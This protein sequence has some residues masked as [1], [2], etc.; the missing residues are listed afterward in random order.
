MKKTYIS[1]AVLVVAMNL[2]QQLC[3]ISGGGTVSV[4]D[5][6]EDAVE[7]SQSL[8]RRYD[9]WGDEEEEEEQL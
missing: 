5:K 4:S 2:E 6:T 9:A 8:S 7:T 3:T 1:P